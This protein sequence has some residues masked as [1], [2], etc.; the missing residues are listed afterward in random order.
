MKIVRACRRICW[1][2]TRGGARAVEKPVA[3]Q[4]VKVEEGGLEVIQRERA[5][6]MPGQ[7]HPLPR[8]EVGKDLLAGGGNF[9]L[10]LLDFL[11]CKVKNTDKADTTLQ[12]VFHTYEHVRPRCISIAPYWLLRHRRAPATSTP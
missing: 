12:V 6:G 3:M 11:L 1:A 7:L 5:F 9:L 4:F 10:D 2:W 8:G